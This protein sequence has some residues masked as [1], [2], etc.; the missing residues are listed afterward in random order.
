IQRLT[1]SGP[2]AADDKTLDSIVDT[3]ILSR[4]GIF[5]G[6]VDLEQIMTHCD[7]TD[8]KTWAGTRSQS[9]SSVRMNVLYQ[10]LIATTR[11]EAL[12]ILQMAPRNHRAIGWKRLKEECG[13]KPE[14]RLTAVRVG[15]LRFE[16]RAA[17]TKG[18]RAWEVAWKEREQSVSLYGDQSVEKASGG[19][20]VAAIT[21]WAP[22]GVKAVI[23]QAMG[24]TG[25]DYNVLARVVTDF[26]AH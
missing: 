22:H 19:T 6:L 3:K 20:K 8:E 13:P 25:Q 16:R 18:I 2:A 10:L 5:L 9:P 1:D 7:V 17:V 26:I 24:A 4:I 12:S 21:R 23:R 14:G 11:G 15:V